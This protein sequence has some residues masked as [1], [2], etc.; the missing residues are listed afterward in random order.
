M[1]AEIINGDYIKNGAGLK[2]TEYFDELLQNIAVVLTAE[3]ERFYPDKDF[4]A[5]IFGNA[6]YALAFA[7]QALYGLNGVYIKSAEETENGFDFTVVINNAERQV[8]VSR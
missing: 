8:A 2:E 3:R 1:T 5:H 7:R 6:D 4:G